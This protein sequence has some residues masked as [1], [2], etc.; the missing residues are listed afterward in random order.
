MKNIQ[1]LI[2]MKNIIVLIGV[3]FLVGC[4]ETQKIPG[5]LVKWVENPDNGLCREKTVGDFTIFAQYKPLSYIICSETRNKTLTEENYIARERELSGME[6]FQVRLQTPN[7][8]PL[9]YGGSDQN[10]YHMRNDFLM[11]GQKDHICLLRG[12]DTVACSMYQ[13]VNYQGLAPYADILLGFRSD[14]S[15]LDS[16]RELIYDDQVFGLGPVHFTFTSD[17]I[18]SVPQLELN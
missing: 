3:L 1:E 11:F 13:F 7:P 5:D 8:D 6:Y 12:A 10:S 4:F 18:E 14:S 17:E 16:D 15:K 9:I 2:D